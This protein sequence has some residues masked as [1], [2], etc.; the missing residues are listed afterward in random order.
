MTIAQYNAL[1]A[2]YEAQQK[3][4]DLRTALLCSIM[5]EPYRDK[6]KRLNP[7]TPADFMPKKKKNPSDEQ[8]MLQAKAIV[9]SLGGEI[10]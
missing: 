9:L 8:M 6:K 10:K 5:A 3:R 1:V 7:F 4:Q 2:Q